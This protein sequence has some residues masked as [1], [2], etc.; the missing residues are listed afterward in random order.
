MPIALKRLDE[1]LDLAVGAWPARPGGQVA[2]PVA[3]E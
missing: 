2:D 3:G 1:A